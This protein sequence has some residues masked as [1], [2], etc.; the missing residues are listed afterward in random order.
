LF[1]DIY[2]QDN[3]VLV[4]LEENL[5]QFMRQC[6]PEEELDVNK[7]AKDLKSGDVSSADLYKMLDDDFGVGPEMTWNNGALRR[8]DL[9][10]NYIPPEQQATIKNFCDKKNITLQL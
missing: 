1:T 6:D 7:M 4:L 9:R 3:G 5:M 8:I 2:P 10:N